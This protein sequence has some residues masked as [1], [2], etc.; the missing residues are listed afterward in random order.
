[1]ERLI[2]L[3]LK[4]EQFMVFEFKRSKV[5]KDTI[6]NIIEF[7]I[8][9]GIM[10]LFQEVKDI[11][12]YLLGVEVGIDTNARKNR[13]GDIFER[14]CQQ[15]IKRL[16]EREYT[17]VNNDPNFSLYPIVTKGKSKGKTHD[18]VIYKNNKPNSYS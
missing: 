18:T 16:V 3:I 13:S 8:K 1:M 14:M 10:D 2:F 6:P 11:H 15:K 5:S 17:L 12:D 9:T 7:C 4:V